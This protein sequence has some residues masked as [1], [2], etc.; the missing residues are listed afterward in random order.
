M[1]RKKLQNRLLA[2]SRM[3]TFQPF[4]VASEYSL[5]PS[6]NAHQYVC[7]QA[8]FSTSW[9]PCMSIQ[10]NYLDATNAVTTRHHIPTAIRSYIENSRGL[11]SAIRGRQLRSVSHLPDAK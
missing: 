7:G 3:P 8:G 11:G 1:D 2:S 10:S 5:S 9:P 4:G 6:S